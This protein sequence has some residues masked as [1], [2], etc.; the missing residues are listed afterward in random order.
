MLRAG[1]VHHQIED[2]ADAALVRF[3][4]K[5]L[6]VRVGPV[7]P[8]DGLVVGGVVSVIARRF[9]DRH[10]PDRID[11]E[12][13]GG[14]GIAIV[15]VIEFLD[16]AVEVADAIGPGIREAA[17]E[18]LVEHRSTGPLVVPLRHRRR[19]RRGNRLDRADAG[20]HARRRVAGQ[21]E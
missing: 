18:D 17:D 11:A 1:V 19:N 8:G 15:E 6:E 21:D 16:Q 10:E 13:G 9:K 4:Q 5:A 20:V 12:V 2:D 7:V 3:L 14:G